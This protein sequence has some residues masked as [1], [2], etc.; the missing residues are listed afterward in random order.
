MKY[1]DEYHIT[2]EYRTGGA[3]FPR[4]PHLFI[5][6][7]LVLT[8]LLIALLISTA[9]LFKAELLSS[10]NTISTLSLPE[11]PV[12]PDHSG[13]YMEGEVVTC[14]EIGFRCQAISDFCKKLYSLPSGVYIVSVTQN[15]PAA[16]LGVLPG[17]I[18]IRINEESLRS[19]EIL[20]QYLRV[21]PK[22][23]RIALSFIRK[24]KTY[25]VYF[26]PGE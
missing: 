5:A 26:S 6:V 22:N 16:K 12:A 14:E 3:V 2:N 24:E 19:P 21:C 13:L 1:R 10:R 7:I 25:T 17:D 23:G 18:L 15:T 20:Q 4:H 9:L 8:L 11:A